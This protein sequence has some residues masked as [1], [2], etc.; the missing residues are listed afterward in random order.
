MIDVLV[1]R[2]PTADTCPDEPER[3]LDRVWLFQTGQGSFWFG[4][5]HRFRIVSIDVGDGLAVTIVYGGD[6]AGAEAFINLSQG[7]V[8]S[9]TFPKETP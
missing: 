6:P 5:K 9:L 7:V 4:G 1:A 8:D 2:T 3:M